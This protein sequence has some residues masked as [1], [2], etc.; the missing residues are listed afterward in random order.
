VVNCMKEI[1]FLIYCEL[2][3]SDFRKKPENSATLHE[4][5]YAQF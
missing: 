5:S 4:I 1:N 2:A 3:V